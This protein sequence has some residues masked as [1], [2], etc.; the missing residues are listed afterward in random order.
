[1]P[2][3]PRDTHRYVYPDGYAG[4]TNNPKR[5]AGEQRR[6]GRKGQML[7]VGPRVTRKAALD[8]ERRQRE[9]KRGRR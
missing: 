6:A 9:K 8:W 5:R 2:R 3:A 4:I 7:V 1:M